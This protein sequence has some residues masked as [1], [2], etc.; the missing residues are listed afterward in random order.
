[1]SLIGNIVWLVFGGLPAALA[2]IV[3]G[4]GM[5]LTIIGFPWG[6]MAIK[7]GLQVLLPFGTRVVARQRSTGCLSVVASIIWIVFAGWIL[8]LMHIVFGVILLVT[9]IGAPFA[10]QHFKLI[11]VAL[12]PFGYEL[13]TA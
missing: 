4:V 11:P 5:C 9:I 1:M 10:M 3:G 8:A 2:Y 12:D 7:L 6:V 13:A